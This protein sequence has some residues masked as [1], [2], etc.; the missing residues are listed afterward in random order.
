VQQITSHQSLTADNTMSSRRQHLALLLL[1]ALAVCAASQTL[2]TPVG[3]YLGC[4]DLS[5]LQV[6]SAQVGAETTPAGCCFGCTSA[7]R[8]D[9]C[10]FVLHPYIAT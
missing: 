5:Q 2:P 10:C 6:D 7:H 1:A 3:G 4:F 8:I 9:A